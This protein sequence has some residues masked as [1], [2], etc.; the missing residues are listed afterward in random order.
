MTRGA[1][2][3]RFGPGVAVLLAGLIVAAASG[4]HLWL[5]VA[6]L[7]IVGVGGVWI[8]AAAFYEIGLSEDRQRERDRRP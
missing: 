7:V 6:G 1:I 2:V 4:S 5:Q 3:R 8:V